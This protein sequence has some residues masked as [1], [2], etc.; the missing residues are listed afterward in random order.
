MK[1][2]R[3]YHHHIILG[4]CLAAWVG[5]NAGCNGGGGNGPDIVSSGAQEVIDEGREFLWVGDYY[6]AQ[7][8]FYKAI[9]DYEEVITPE[10]QV[11]ALYGFIV[12]ETFVA[13]SEFSAQMEKMM[14]T[15]GNLLEG[16]GAELFPTQ[17]E[18][19]FSVDVMVNDLVSGLMLREADLIRGFI[20]D[21]NAVAAEHGI[22]P[23]FDID[24]PIPEDD[25]E[26]VDIPESIPIYMGAENQYEWMIITG[27]LDRGDLDLLDSLLSVV[28]GLGEVI[29]SIHWEVNLNAL[30]NSGIDVVL[31]ILSTI[32][33]PIVPGQLYLVGP[34][35]ADVPLIPAMASILAYTLNK[36]PLFLKLDY[37]ET[38]PSGGGPALLIDAADKI[39]EGCDGFIQAFEWIRNEPV[40]GNGPI[41]IV[42]KEGKEYFR[43]KYSQVERTGIEYP[44]DEDETRIDIEY[45]A[46][47]ISA[48]QAIQDSAAAE[49][50]TLVSW[51]THLSWVLS[52]AA[53]NMIQTGALSIILD[54]TLGKLSQDLADS[55]KTYLA[56]ANTPDILKGVLGMVTGA[57]NMV[58]LDLGYALR[59][60]T[61]SHLRGAIPYW[62]RLDAEGNG[63]L[64]LEYECNI[65]TTT[66]DSY[67][68]GTTATFCPDPSVD[69]GAITDSGHFT[70]L[71]PKEQPSDM[72]AL[73]VS[74]P[75]SIHADEIFGTIPYLAWQ[76]PTINGL[77]YLKT[78]NSIEPADN[79]KIN[80][81][82]QIFYRDLMG[83]MA[84]ALP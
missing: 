10:E 20:A 49:S 47:F 11:E 83:F 12:S 1:N 40:P 50:G 2:T 3:V 9:E 45:K 18:Y 48:I 4:L 8:R 64:L 38:L 81:F 23:G 52:Y 5:M 13:I 65:P 66:A 21:L 31:A 56:I 59:H 63:Y 46:E 68:L 14:T 73:G 37:T 69:P 60:P 51:D 80:V 77:L 35:D 78:G 54:L 74:V 84:T 42:T 72:K 62:T 7:D 22:E 33:I 79:W 43:I 55:L 57:F 41:S 15:V 76:D 36:S 71:D 25:P 70:A 61:E 24:I 44:T 32:P 34:E 19:A 30:I 28:Q 6:S 75:G 53:V 26:A 27:R 17:T 16:T 82:T 58:Y 67:P 29:L 39:V